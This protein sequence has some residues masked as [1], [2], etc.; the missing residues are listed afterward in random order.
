M[1]ENLRTIRDG[2]EFIRLGKIWNTEKEMLVRCDIILGLID[3][4]IKGEQQ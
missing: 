3:K 2:V 4:I 1:M